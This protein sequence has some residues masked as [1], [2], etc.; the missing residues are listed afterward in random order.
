MEYL[1]IFVHYMAMKKKKQKI[2]YQIPKNGSL[3]IL[4]FGAKGVIEWRKVR[5]KNEDTNGQ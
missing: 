1:I 4:A 2:K 3:S 5:S